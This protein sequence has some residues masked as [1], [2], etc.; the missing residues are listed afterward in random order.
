MRIGKFETF[1]WSELKRVWSLRWAILTALQAAIPAAYTA[2]PADLLPSIP[3][4]IKH[5]LVFSTLF[6]AAGT[7]VARVVK[8]PEPK[9]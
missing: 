3:A 1:A 5:A 2:L 6:T 7:A 8:Q 4:W 9:A